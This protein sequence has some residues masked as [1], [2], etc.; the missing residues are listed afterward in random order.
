MKGHLF[1]N[2]VFCWIS[3]EPASPLL[4]LDRQLGCCSSLVLCLY[5]CIYWKLGEAKGSCSFL[6]CVHC[7]VWLHWIFL[8]L[9][10]TKKHIPW[11]W[12]YCCQRIQ[13]DVWTVISCVQLLALHFRLAIVNRKVYLPRFVKTQLAGCRFVRV[14]VCAMSQ[15]CEGRLEGFVV[16]TG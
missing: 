6:L 8:K 16:Y 15:D 4:L 5:K 3:I 13:H 7:R 11:L 10:I 12:L 1:L 9:S 14:V 2:K